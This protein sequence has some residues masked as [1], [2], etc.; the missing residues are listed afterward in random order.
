MTDEN[1]KTTKLKNLDRLLKDC[2]TFR[3]MQ[4]LLSQYIL[5]EQYFMAQSVQ[6][7]TIRKAAKYMFS[8]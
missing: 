4:M 2:E 1:E 7:V 8:V 6:K 3:S 5:L